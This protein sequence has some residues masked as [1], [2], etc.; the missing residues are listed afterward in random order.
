MREL[1][2]AGHDCDRSAA[3]WRDLRL[4]RFKRVSSKDTLSG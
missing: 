4:N 1:R 2:R 3:E